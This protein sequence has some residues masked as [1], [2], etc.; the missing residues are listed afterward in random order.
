MGSVFQQW[1]EAATEEGYW[2]ESLEFFPTPTQEVP[3]PRRDLFIRHGNLVFNSGH[4]ILQE[5]VAEITQS[6]VNRAIEYYEREGLEATVAYYNSEESLEGLFYLFLMDENDI[7]IA[8]PILPHLIGTDIKDVVG[9]DGQELGKEIAQATEAGIWVEYLWPHPISGFIQDKTT[10]AIRHDGLIFASGYYPLSDVPGPQP[11]LDADPQE[12]TV[13]YVENAIERYQHLGLDA[14]TTYYNSVASFEDQWYLFVIDANDIYVVH[15]IFPYFIGTKD[16]KDVVDSSGY[17]L[18]KDIA[19]ATVEGHWVEYLW[20]HPRTLAEVPKVSYVVRHDGLIFASGY[21]PPVEDPAEYTQAYAQQAIERYERE[22]IEAVVAYY[23][24]P[25]SVDRQW[26]LTLLDENGV[27]LTSALFPHLLSRNL[28]AQ[29][30][31]PGPGNEQFREDLANTTEAGHWLE[32]Q[33]H[34]KLRLWAIRHDGYIF[35]T[36]YL[37]D[38]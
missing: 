14:M 18:G 33:L 29:D 21:Y 28:L 2:V 24:S 22:G 26:Y 1:V 27:V 23:N 8:H 12:Y 6:Y 4:Y 32:V 3:N 35:L 37:P 20:P 11:W 7:Y 13:T 38:Q 19:S 36:N 5:N 25:L 9:S 10:Y 31:L 34:V 16:I 15:P 17:E 30:I